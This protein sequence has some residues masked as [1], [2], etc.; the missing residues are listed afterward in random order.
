MNNETLKK[1]LRLLF[2]RRHGR[3][4]VITRR[5]LRQILYLSDKED[6]QL[7]NAI[8]DLRMS[9]MPILF[10]ASKPAGYYIPGSLAGFDAENK[11]GIPDIRRSGNR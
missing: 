8:S 3:T 9:G 11:I 7:R 5:E 6:R 2:E 10:S 1:E 4:N